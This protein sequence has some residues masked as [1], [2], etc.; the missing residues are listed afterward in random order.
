MNARG[1]LK[2]LLQLS[3]KLSLSGRKTENCTQMGNKSCQTT[4]WCNASFSDKGN[5]MSVI[6]V[7][8]ARDLILMMIKQ[9]LA[10]TNIHLAHTILQYL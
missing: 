7:H 8:K 10:K 9:K 3:N 6:A 1:V 5:G 4:F 2:R